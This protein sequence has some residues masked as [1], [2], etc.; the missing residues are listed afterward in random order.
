MAAPEMAPEMARSEVAAGQG[1][2]PIAGR[3][4]QRAEPGVAEPDARTRQIIG[5]L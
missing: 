4:R 2:A 3:D 1:L 5:R